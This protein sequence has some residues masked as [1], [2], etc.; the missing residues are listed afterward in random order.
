M[1]SIND[2]LTSSGF[3]IFILILVIV[4]YNRIMAKAFVL[5]LVKLP[6]WGKLIKTMAWA[7]VI[8]FVY[9]AGSELWNRKVKHVDPVVED[10][11]SQLLGRAKSEYEKK[12][13]SIDPKLPVREQAKQNHNLVEELKGDINAINNPPKNCPDNQKF[14]DVVLKS[15][16]KTKRLSM[17][18]DACE[19]GKEI[20]IPMPNKVDVVEYKATLLVRQPDGKMAEVMAKPVIKEMDPTQGSVAKEVT[21]TAL[22]PTYYQLRGDVKY[23]YQGNAH[24]LELLLMP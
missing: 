19:V 6:H 14:E 5:W 3:W 21:T 15:G 17:D 1:P 20:L 16:V 22:F 24:R 12:A 11:H 2:L 18:F 9:F 8:A 7:V 10:K 23:E 13:D 4:W